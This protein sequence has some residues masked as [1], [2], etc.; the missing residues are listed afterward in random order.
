MERYFRIGQF[1]TYLDW[2][3]ILTSKDI[4]PPEPKLY[5][6]D[7]GG[8][9]GTIDLSEALTSEVVYKDRTISATFWTDYGT[10]KDRVAILKRVRNIHGRRFKIYEPDDPE[11]YFMGRVNI[12]GEL[13]TLSYAEVSMEMICEPYRYST[14]YIERH[15]V[16]EADTDVNV[17]LNNNGHKIVGLTITVNSGTLTFS[18]GTALTTGTYTDYTVSP[19]ANIL[20]FSG[21]AADATL[22]YREVYI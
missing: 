10:R 13:N 21:V 22:S 6:V 15:V 12:L 3:L 1:N 18:D 8:M 9:D 7:V 5:Y 14:D 20:E 4:T 19:G 17:V 11:H 2:H 16:V